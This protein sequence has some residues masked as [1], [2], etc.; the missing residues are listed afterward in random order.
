MH[1]KQS[2]SIVLVI[3]AARD[4]PFF[5]QKHSCNLSEKIEHRCLNFFSFVWYNN[6]ASCLGFLLH[7]VHEEATKGRMVW[8]VYRSIS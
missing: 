8:V 1:Y 6:Y 5:E 4:S 7:L 3:R 2:I